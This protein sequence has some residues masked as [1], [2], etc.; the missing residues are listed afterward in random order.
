MVDFIKSKKLDKIS[1]IK[2]GFF[3][4]SGGLSDGIYSSLNCGTRS[5][6]DVRTVTKNR[7]LAL[8]SLAS[9]AALIEV[10]QTHSNTVH[11]FSGDFS[12][13]DADAIV[14]DRKN[15]ALSVV[16]A[17]CAPVLLADSKASVIGAAHA[18]WQGAMDGI[19]ENVVEAMCELGATCE[20]IE[21]AIG[22]CISQAS[23]EVGPEFY[24]KISDENYF[25]PS[26]KENHYLF[27]LESYVSDRLWQSKI[28][29]IEPLKM[30]TYNEKNDFFSYRRKTHHGE[31][32]YGRQ[33]S[34]I[35]QR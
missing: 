13:V 3:T 18:G 30:D 24:E 9:G 11:K 29:K 32:D 12:V 33:I 21:A 4:R 6:D 31:N 2:H 19:I 14:T 35:L 16:T 10:H 22:P 7:I 27:D 1:S 5:N 25:K 26:A 28:T 8:N 34:I 17:D 23:Y 15:I 20:N